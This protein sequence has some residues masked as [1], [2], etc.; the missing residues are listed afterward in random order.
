MPVETSVSACRRCPARRLAAPAS[1]RVTSAVPS[2][3]PTTCLEDDY[4]AYACGP[5]APDPACPPSA[6]RSEAR[7]A[8]SRDVELVGLLR[9]VQDW[10]SATIAVVRSRQR[11][12]PERREFPR[13]VGARSG[14]AAASRS[15]R[16][17]ARRRGTV[18]PRTRP[19]RATSVWPRTTS[20]SPAA[21]RSWPRARLPR[22]PFLMRSALRRRAARV[23]A[24]G[25]E[26]RAPFR[27]SPRLLRS[28]VMALCR[29]PGY[30]VGPSLRPASRV[31]SRALPPPLGERRHAVRGSR[32]PLPVRRRPR[33]PVQIGEETRARGGHHRVPVRRA[34]PAPV[35]R[36]LTLDLRQAAPRLLLDR[37]DRDDAGRGRLDKTSTR[38]AATTCSSSRASRR[39]DAIST[40]ITSSITSCCRCSTS[41]AATI[42]ICLGESRSGRGD[43]PLASVSRPPTSSPAPCG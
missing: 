17:I 21:L 18:G 20:R 7:S 23:R 30:P 15:R 22:P 16:R 3:S 4:D 37:L 12:L 33:L 27:R 31:L 1:G 19:M 28:R 29:L 32:S 39:K 35:N 42:P 43:A 26:K 5:R 25:T 13:S 36:I 2:S 34:R 10:V 14:T 6:L 9:E 8:R 41:K 38:S 24:V 40:A 11:Y